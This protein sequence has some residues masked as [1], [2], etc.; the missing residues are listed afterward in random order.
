MT[1][2]KKQE[3]QNTLIYHHIKE[4]ALRLGKMGAG[5]RSVPAPSR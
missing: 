4:P 5:S 3:S 1:G 2:Y